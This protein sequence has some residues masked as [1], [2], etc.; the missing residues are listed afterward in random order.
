MPAPCQVITNGYTN[1]DSLLIDCL[2]TNVGEI[3]IKINDFDSIKS[4]GKCSLH[5]NCQ[6]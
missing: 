3:Q 1:A 6:G 2:G 4:I 5:I